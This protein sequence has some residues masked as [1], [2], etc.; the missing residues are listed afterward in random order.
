MTKR[1][2]KALETSIRHWERIEA[3]KDSEGG[4][5]NCALCKNYGRNECKTCPVTD[6]DPRRG[7]CSNTPY[8]AWR[9]HHDIIDHVYSDRKVRCPECVV[10]AHAEVE[11]LRSL[12]DE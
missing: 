7:G 12:R 3:G 11:F 1:Q 6:K 10:L 9:S 4:G 8:Y 5:N 2:S